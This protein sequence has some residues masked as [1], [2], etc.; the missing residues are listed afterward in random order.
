MKEL[1]WPILDFFSQHC[2][3]LKVSAGE[4]A[5]YME[6]TNTESALH[7][8]GIIPIS[9]QTCYDFSRVEPRIPSRY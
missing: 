5:H 2:A 1:V 4:A 8:I 6:K 3:F 9:L 7:S